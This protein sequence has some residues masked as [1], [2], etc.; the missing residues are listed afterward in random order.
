M[1]ASKT[2]KHLWRNRLARSAV[3]RKVAGSSP[4]RCEKHLFFSFSAVI[5][6]NTVYMYNVHVHVHTLYTHMHTF[7][8]IS[9]RNIIIHSSSHTHHREMTFYLMSL[10]LRRTT[11]V[12]SSCSTSTSPGRRRCRSSRRG[13]RGRTE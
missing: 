2:A 10:R 11:L 1:Y 4:A 7:L 5:I 9:S 8:T 12:R 13:K 3:N 6:T